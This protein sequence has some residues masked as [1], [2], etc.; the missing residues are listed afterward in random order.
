L[1]A[2]S[3]RSPDAAHSAAAVLSRLDSSVLQL[4]GGRMRACIICK[5]LTGVIAYQGSR[6]MFGGIG[7]GHMMYGGNSYYYGNS[8]QPVRHLLLHSL[9]KGP[10]SA[11]QL[12]TLHILHTRK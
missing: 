10:L 9:I 5:K 8:Y 12:R 3:I 1:V 2:T 6:M 7:G 11:C 4:V